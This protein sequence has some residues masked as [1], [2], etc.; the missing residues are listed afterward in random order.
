MFLR[1]CMLLPLVVAGLW[2]CGPTALHLDRAKTRPWTPIENATCLQLIDET[3]LVIE[4]GVEDGWAP[5]ARHGIP[6]D[7]LF[8]RGTFAYRRYEDPCAHGLSRSVRLLIRRQGVTVDSVRFWDLKSPYV[9]GE[10][11][12]SYITND[13]GLSLNSCFTVF[14]GLDA[15]DSIP[16]TDRVSFLAQEL[17]EGR[18]PPP[19]TG[20]VGAYR[21]LRSHLWPDSTRPI[22]HVELALLRGRTRE[23]HRLP[24]DAG[25]LL[26]VRKKTP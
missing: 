23:P 21:W 22:L 12:C 8:E 6:L 16:L 18:L 25:T 17:E 3:P 13:D 5:L 20:M 19:D 11:S 26:L 10:Q 2:G 24:L 9:W 14:L 1:L 15:I 4:P 7:A